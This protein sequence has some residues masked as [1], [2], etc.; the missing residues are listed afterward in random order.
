MQHFLRNILAFISGLIVGSIVNGSLISI[1]GFVI[2]PPE[3]ANISTMDGLKAAIPLFEPKHFL[4]P[5]TAHALGTLV[6]AFVAAK[7]APKY[8]LQ[9][10]IG[11]GLLFLAGGITNIYLLPSPVWFTIVDLAVAYIPMAAIGWM[12]S[13]KK[14]KFF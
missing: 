4:F 10:A 5:F 7:I 9:L 11:V 14:S 13:K 12:L 8:G 3:G 1:S 2:P 6:G